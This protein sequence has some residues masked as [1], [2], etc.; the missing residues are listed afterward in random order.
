MASQMPAII[1]RQFES[2]SVE[3][4]ARAECSVCSHIVE[5]ISL[6]PFIKLPRKVSIGTAESLLSSDCKDHAALVSFLKRSR[7]R[8]DLQNVELQLCRPTD[9]ASGV[10]LMIATTSEY[11]EVVEQ[12][13]FEQQ[14]RLSPQIG[15]AL[16][17][18]AEWINVELLR[19]WKHT[20]T[21]HHGTKCESPYKVFDIPKVHPLWL[22]DTQEL[23]LVPGLVANSF[24]TLSYVWGDL[25]HFTTTEDNLNRL[26]KRGAFSR[27]CFAR[28]IPETIAHSIALVPLL[29]ERFLWVDAL[30]IVQDSDTTKIDEIN[31]MAA[32][33]ASSVLTIIAGDGS[34]CHYGLRGIRQ[35]SNPRHIEQNIEPFGPKDALVGAIFNRAHEVLYLSTH[36]ERA[37]TFQESIFAKRRLI[38]Q[39]GSVRWMCS[40]SL[41]DEDL[42]SLDLDDSP[43]NR[44]YSIL[45]QDQCFPSFS[46]LSVAV[47]TFN[48]RELMYPEDAISAITGFL[49]ILS[50]TFDGGF[51]FGIPE[52]FFD[53]ALLWEPT[54]DMMRRKPMR[55]RENLTPSLQIP[56]W[57]WA[58]WTGKFVACAWS[59]YETTDNIIYP[60]SL[61]RVIPTV[62]WYAMKSPSS[63]FR[64][65]INTRW[66]EY[67]SGAQDLTKSL[68]SGWE[69]RENA[70]ENIEGGHYAYYFT[71]TTT[72]GRR[73][74]WPFPIPQQGKTPTIPE[75]TPFLF[76]RTSRAHVFANRL[77]QDVPSSSHQ[78]FTCSLTDI[79]GN[80]VGVL[81]LQD[82][83]GMDL[84]Q[85]NQT[86]QMIE[87]VSISQTICTE[88]DKEYT[89]ERRYGKLPKDAPY[90][91]YN[92]LWIGREMGV[93][94][95]KGL[96]RVL[97]E[98]WERLREEEVIDLI[99]G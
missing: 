68:P 77:S 67:R 70:G 39:K 92:V 59:Y 65:Q 91:Y 83:Q 6:P 53:I 13:H 37:W 24:V 34:D 11:S 54:P 35:V 62:Q 69:R 3:V 95:R 79:E 48:R 36:R 63:V 64:K 51:L 78:G 4:K 66:F 94:Y 26:K 58:A 87:V 12:L 97:G 38:F 23:C 21:T 80:W 10:Y 75:P 41:W 74:K 25:N 50:Q 98:E 90:E 32:I 76:C 19:Q 55:K 30:C 7:S 31:K 49:N 16:P 1:G 96:G 29:E 9:I 17:L 45:R 14:T 46:L 88:P 5:F 52:A 61:R 60:R 15:R 40:E 56:T 18:D 20:C 93:A 27:E 47:N 81:F 28:F 89:A 71:H 99:L 8:D 33:Y 82:Q 44:S 57:S 72:P 86:S 2:I 85:C 42:H 73:W 43:K 22:I 84:I